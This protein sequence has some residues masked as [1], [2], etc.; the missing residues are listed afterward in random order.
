M[1]EN[2]FA[3]R[4]HEIQKQEERERKLAEDSKKGTIWTSEMPAN[5]I[6]EVI[7][8]AHPDLISARISHWSFQPDVIWVTLPDGKKRWVSNNG[9]FEQR[10]E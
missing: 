7:F 3:K 4:W 8:K 10:N 9:T 1:D 2:W 5:T 6:P